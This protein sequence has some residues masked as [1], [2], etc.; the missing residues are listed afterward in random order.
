M[1]AAQSREDLSEMGNYVDLSEDNISSG[2]GGEGTN[3]G[4][5]G[6]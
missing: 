4:P 6:V 3:S 5:S 2:E 1:M